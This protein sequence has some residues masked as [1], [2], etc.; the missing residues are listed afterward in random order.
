MWKHEEW[1]KNLCIISKEQN[2]WDSHLYISPS[3]KKKVPLFFLTLSQNQMHLSENEIFFSG[4]SSVV[5][6][7]NP[8]LWPRNLD[9]YKNHD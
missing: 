6:G 7:N 1:K 9:L 3:T 8:L 4:K 5:S 2:S